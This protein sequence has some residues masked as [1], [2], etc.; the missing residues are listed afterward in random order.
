M[1]HLYLKSN[2][3][4]YN[5]YYK[6]M[7]SRIKS[8]FNQNILVDETQDENV[9]EKNPVPVAVCV[10]LLEMAHADDEF[11]DEEMAEII[12]VM[13]EEF[14]LS[15]EETQKILKIADEER[16]ESI[17]LW[18]FSKLISDHCDRDKK[19]RI[20]DTLW[21]VIYSDGI[22]DAHEDYLVHKLATILDLSH[23]EL[24]ESKLRVKH[25]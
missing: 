22:L 18:Q 16:K 14:E 15:H 8:F 24:I 5:D 25:R 3:S 10:L 17:D 23:R 6:I 9:Q 4:E 13:E 20:M 7:L 2:Y 19:L 21:S 11:T 1:P 12:S